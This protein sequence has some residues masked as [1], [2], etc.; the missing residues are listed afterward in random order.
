VGSW[1]FDAI[2]ARIAVIR[3]HVRA[4]TRRASI[5]HR[6]LPLLLAASALSLVLGSPVALAVGVIKA[7]DSPPTFTGCTSG[8]THPPNNPS[9]NYRDSEVEPWLAVNPANPANLIGAWQQDRWSDGGAHGLTA[10]ASFDGGLT[11]TDTPLPFDACAA[12][13]DPVASIYNRASDPWVSIGP[14]GTA[15]AV[16][17]SINTDTNDGAVLASTSRNGGLSWSAPSIVKADKGTSPTLFEIT[18]FFDDKESVTADP[19]K[20]GVAYAVWDRLV[21]PSQAFDADLHAAAFRGP[22]WFSKTTDGG[23]TWQTRQIFDPGEK[24][25][26]I[27]NV[28]VVDP[29]TG[30]LYDFF[31]LILSTGPKAPR[32]TNV[33]FLSSTDGGNTWSGPTIVSSLLTVGVSDPNNVDPRTNTA[34]VSLRTGDLTPEPA[35]DPLTGQLYVVWQDSRFNGG[36]FD[37]VAISTSTNGGKTWSAPKRVNSPSG[38]AAFTPSVAVNSAHTVGVSYYQ[39]EVSTSLGSEPTVYRLKQLTPAQVAA[40]SATTLEAVAATTVLGPFN[41]LDAPFASGYFT[42][43]YEGLASSGTTF[44][45][46]VVATNCADLSC[47]ALTAVTPPADRTPTGF[48]STDVYV[49]LAQ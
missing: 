13:N 5:V 41:M 27:G 35:I 32:G 48:N 17:I 4:V 3:W 16:S 20:P 24:N 6:R 30:T 44:L 26:T 46:F 49:G 14:D 29:R 40:T 21:S 2:E 45:P 31:D 22:T 12:P 9:F 1:P 23:Q 36:S 10:G 33:A 15:Y 34:P 18:R 42:G 8:A 47:R 28:I 19:N 43:D 39:W 7:S 38:H 25:Q 11:W 37:E